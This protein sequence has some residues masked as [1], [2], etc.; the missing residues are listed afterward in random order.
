MRFSLFFSFCSDFLSTLG[1]LLLFLWGFVVDLSS[2]RIWVWILWWG[3]LFRWLYG[4]F[5]FTDFVSRVLFRQIWWSWVVRW[6]VVP[7]VL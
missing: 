2:R 3:F 7:Q 5:C 6:V 4:G 1:H